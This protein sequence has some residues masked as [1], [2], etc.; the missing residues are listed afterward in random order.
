MVS[1]TGDRTHRTGAPGPQA[2]PHG[3]GH[4]RFAWD[5]RTDPPVQ[6]PGPEGLKDYVAGGKL[7][8]NGTDAYLSTGAD[9]FTSLVPRRKSYATTLPEQLDQLKTDPQMLRF[10]E[11]RRRLAADPYRPVYHY[12]NPEGTLQQLEELLQ[13]AL[14]RPTGLR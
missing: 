3:A 9:E 12:V 1:F 10:A 8:L 7:H 13:L 2:L 4:N 5:L 6:I 11:S 14:E